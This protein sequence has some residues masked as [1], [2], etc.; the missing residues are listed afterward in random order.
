MN[1]ETEEISVNDALSLPTVCKKC[2]LDFRFFSFYMIFVLLK[3][4]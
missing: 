1:Y 3:L 2:S 4:F